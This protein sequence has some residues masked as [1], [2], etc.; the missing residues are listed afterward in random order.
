[1]SGTQ[2]LRN[3]AA[4]GG[5]IYVTGDLAGTTLILNVL[6]G[7]NSASTNGAAVYLYN[8]GKR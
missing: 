8:S 3:S 5:G 7:A 6:L 2:L 1:M 4:S